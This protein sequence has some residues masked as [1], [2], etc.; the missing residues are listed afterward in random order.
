MQPRVVAENAHAHFP[1]ANA[2]QAAPERRK[3]Q[4]IEYTE[5]GDE[6]TEHQVKPVQVA[7]H[8]D[9][10][11]R[12]AGQVEAVV[13]AGERVPAIG[14]PPDTLS[15]RQRD[16]QKVDAAR[17]DGNESEQGGGRRADERAQHDHRR[18][19]PSQ[20]EL[21]FGGEDRGEIGADAEVGG[22][23]ERGEAGEAE[24]D[25]EA[26][27]EDGEHQRAGDEQDDERTGVRRHHGDDDEDRDDR[28]QLAPVRHAGHGHSRPN[29]PVGLTAS[30][31]AIG[32]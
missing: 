4:E 1:L 18:E 30:N 14:E 23:A 9:A 13:A 15:E 3:D 21:V 17:P 2:F 5:G 27:G 20:A 32:A 31:R 8:G 6:E 29:R 12:P 10:E 22:L 28:Q 19:V 26:H 7:G 11:G 24:Q 25:V 16:H